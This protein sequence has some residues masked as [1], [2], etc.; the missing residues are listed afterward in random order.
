M[1][2]KLAFKW[3]CMNEWCG[4]SGGQV[5]GHSAGEL[6]VQGQVH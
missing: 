2:S 6:G 5:L 3:G 4:G 1:R